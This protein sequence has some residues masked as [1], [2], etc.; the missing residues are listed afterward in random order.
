[1]WLLATTLQQAKAMPICGMVM[2]IA[3]NY[4]TLNLLLGLG[5]LEIICGVIY[6]FL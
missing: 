4:L 2:M 3:S 6:K 5:N 1:M